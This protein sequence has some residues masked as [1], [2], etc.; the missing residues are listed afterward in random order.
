MPE[1][2]PFWGVLAQPPADLRRLRL[3]LRARRVARRREQLEVDRF[4]DAIRS[5]QPPR[6]W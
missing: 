4:L 3:R 6:M 1:P 2:H 5:I